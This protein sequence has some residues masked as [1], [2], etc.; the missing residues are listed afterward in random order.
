LWFYK[1]NKNLNQFFEECPESV[2]E[3][4]KKILK[5]AIE[6]TANLTTHSHEEIFARIKMGL[7]TF[8]PVTFSTD[9]AKHTVLFFIQENQFVICNR[10]R[11]AASHQ[12]VD[13]NQFVP[14]KFTLE[15]I[16]R[17]NSFLNEKQYQELISELRTLLKF[18]KTVWNTAIEKMNDLPNQTA[19]NCSFVNTS[20]AIYAWMQFI[21]M[22][23]SVSANPSIPMP[24]MQSFLYWMN[25]E[26]IAGLQKMLN[27]AK[28]SIFEPDYLLINEGL[29]KINCNLTPQLKKK[30]DHLIATAQKVEAKRVARP[31]RP[32][33]GRDA[34]VTPL[35]L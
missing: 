15:I 17:M 19:R 22:K 26:K 2:P 21:E 10:F 7:P 30:F 27:L 23:E 24:P 13:F 20:A 33:S 29:K 18:E 3:K 9:D 14:D 6:F 31:S 34:L 4:Q 11:G 28:T 8:I 16:K 1:I 35:N 12:S 32:G 25:F 5:D